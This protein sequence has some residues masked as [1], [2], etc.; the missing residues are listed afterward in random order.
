MEANQLKPLNPVLPVQEPEPLKKTSA[1]GCPVCAATGC[2]VLHTQRFVL[3]EGH[4][5]ASGYDVVCCEQCGFVYADTAGTQADYDAFYARFSKYEDSQTSTGG[6]GFPEDT[7][8][9]RETAACIA[10]ALPDRNARLLDIGCANGGLLQALQELGYT[11]LAGMDPSPVC[12]EATRQLC[13]CDVYVGPFSELPTNIGQFDGVIMSHV[14]EH[15]QDLH[16]ALQCVKSLFSSNGIAYIEVPDASR[17][18]DYYVSPFHFFDT[19]HINHF[20]QTALGNLMTRHNL[21][22]WGQGEKTT[23]LTSEIVYPAIYTFLKRCNDPRSEVVVDDGLRQ[24]IGKYIEMSRSDGLLDLPAD[25]LDNG[26]PVIVW[27]VG[28]STTRLL[29]NSFLGK[30]NIV[31]FTDNNSKHW[32]GSILN[33]TVLNPVDLKS[34]NELIIVTSKIYGQEI[35]SQ[36]IFE[37]QIDPARIVFVFSRM[38]GIAGVQ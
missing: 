19:E 17:Y 15:V 21:I 34:R 1:R 24:S 28:C 33:K 26:T 3:P 30:A 13:Q 38:G 7:L 22:G 12:V 2:E 5:L 10:A 4:P 14:L 25:I 9:L 16:E 23:A 6:G 20:S 35:I 31:A 27:G 36:L 37:L 11:N 32:G 8:R 18:P 29:A